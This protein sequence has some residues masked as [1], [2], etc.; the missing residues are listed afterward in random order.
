MSFTIQMLL[1]TRTNIFFILY[2][3]HVSLQY[4]SC[5][6]EALVVEVC[7]TQYVMPF[8]DL[9][10]QYLCHFR[11][12]FISVAENAG[13]LLAHISSQCRHKLT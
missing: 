6:N 1:S 5:P 7:K 10:R 11:T 8:G 9:L 2:Y 3:P 13:V 12:Q 4:S